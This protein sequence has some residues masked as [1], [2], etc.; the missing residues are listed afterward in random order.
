MSEKKSWNERHAELVERIMAAA[1]AKCDLAPF[2][3]ELK[4]LLAEKPPEKKDGSK[5]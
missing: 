1:V 4:R 2:K 3:D 5:D